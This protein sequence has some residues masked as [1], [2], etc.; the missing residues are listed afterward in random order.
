M[1]AGTIDSSVGNRAGAKDEFVIW[2]KRINPR[3]NFLH[4]KISAESFSP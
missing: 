2:G 1:P 3:R 4:E